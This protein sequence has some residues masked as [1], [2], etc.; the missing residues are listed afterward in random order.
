MGL[1]TELY[2][3]VTKHILPFWD[4]MVDQEY[5]GFYGGMSKEL[6]LN[7]EGLKG[8][9]AAARLLWSYARAYR[10]TGN[11][12]HEEAMVHAYNFLVN[13]VLDETYGGIYWAMDYKGEVLD[14]RKHVYAQS[15]AIYALSEYVLATDSEEAK[16][17]AI[18]LYELVEEVGYSHVYG[19]YLEEFDVQWH[20]KDN[21]ML[22]ENGVVAYFTMNTHLHVLEA[23]TNLYRICPEIKVRKSIKGLLEIFK[24]TIY[25]PDKGIMKVF[26]DEQWRSIIDMNSY[27]HDIEAT[28]LIQEALD[29][30]GEEDTVIDQMIKT[31]GDNILERS[32]QEDGSIINEIEAGVKDYQRV[33]WGQAEAMVGFMNLYQKSGDDKYLKATE[34]MWRYIASTLVDSRQGGEWYYGQE[35]DQSLSKKA[36]VEPWKTPYHNLRGCIEVLERL[37]EIHRKVACPCKQ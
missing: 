34:K 19:G 20:L 26:F 17:I 32:I 11:P 12:L 21:E 25:D 33:W 18:Q 30:L 35:A 23:Y 6:E 10:Y 29:V 16:G 27:G 28:W 37:E 5:G 31:I 7:K 24:G 36:I 2:E 4:K 1:H 3:E 8:G 9:I 13:K 14:E 15:F 22:S